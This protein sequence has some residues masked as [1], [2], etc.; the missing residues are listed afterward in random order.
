MCEKHIIAYLYSPEVTP[1]GWMGS[2]HQPTNKYILFVLVDGVWWI[3]YLKPVANTNLCPGKQRSPLLEWVVLNVSKG[4]FVCFDVHATGN[5]THC[6]CS[7]I[8]AG[9]KR[10]FDIYTPFINAPITCI[11]QLCHPHT[12]VN[13][14]LGIKHQVTY[15]CVSRLYIYCIRY[16]Y[17][18]EIYIHVPWI[19]GFCICFCCVCQNEN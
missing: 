7:V 14:W 10:L 1:C 4:M 13:G 18:R 15:S 17:Y 9:W 11:S 16:T 3:S 5:P 19:R 6:F 12:T 2:K 8:L